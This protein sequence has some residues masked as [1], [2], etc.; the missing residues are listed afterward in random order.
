MCKLLYKS[1]HLI[2]CLIVFSHPPQFKQQL[3]CGKNANSPAAPPPPPLG[4]GLP[5][6]LLLRLLPV[7]LAAEAAA[8]GEAA[9]AVVKGGRVG[10]SSSLG[11]GVTLKRPN[12]GCVGVLEGVC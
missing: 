9:A 5:P 7:R 10:R 4:L 12:T 11:L 8:D 6:P 1:I 3:T 2:F